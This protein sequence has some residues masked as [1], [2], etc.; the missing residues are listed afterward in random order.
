MSCVIQTF[1]LVSSSVSSK[2][3]LCFVHG[4]HQKREQKPTTK[5]FVEF[6]NHSPLVT[7][8]K[9]D[10]TCKIW[11]FCVLGHITSNLNEAIKNFHD[12][13]CLRFVPHDYY[14]YENYILFGNDYG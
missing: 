9:S 5:N 3:L 8:I 1:L 14:S 6:H 13:T 11:S 4:H 7:M 12:N 10:V 2:E